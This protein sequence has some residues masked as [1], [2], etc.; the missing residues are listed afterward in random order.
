MVR[1][2]L[3][4]LTGEKTVLFYSGMGEKISVMLKQVCLKFTKAAFFLAPGLLVILNEEGSF[5]Q[6]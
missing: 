1:A 3:H 4:G 5:L 6:S 2:R